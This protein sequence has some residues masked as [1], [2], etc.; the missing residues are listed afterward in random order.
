[1]TTLTE[2]HDGR[3]I[4]VRQDTLNGLQSKRGKDSERF[5]RGQFGHGFDCL[6]NVG[7]GYLCRAESVA[8]IKAR[9]A[10]A[11]ELARGSGLSPVEVGL[12]SSRE[13]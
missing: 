9:V 13:P 6:T 2:T 10:Q 7:A 3:R 11:A 12:T 5:W 1:M 4:A 8:A